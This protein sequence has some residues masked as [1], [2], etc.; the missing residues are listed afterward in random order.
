[1][2]MYAWRP[3]STKLSASKL[4]LHFTRREEEILALIA[5][6][7]VNKEIGTILGISPRTVSSHLTRLFARHHIRT[8]TQAAMAW[9]FEKE[10]REAT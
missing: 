5:E 3:P 8:R 7:R 10:R 2:A 4:A 1:M 9:A 6:G